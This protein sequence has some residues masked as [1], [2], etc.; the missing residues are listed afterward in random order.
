MDLSKALDHFEKILELFSIGYG[1]VWFNRY[2]EKK[3]IERKKPSLEDID[4]YERI[5][6]ALETIRDTLNPNI[7]AFWEGSNGETT[8]S[9]FHKKKLSLV[10]ESVS[11]D[12]YSGIGELDNIPAINFKRNIDLLRTS[13]Y[14]Y[15]VS[16]EFEKFDELAALHQSYEIGTLVALKIITGR[17]IKKWTG[18][19]VVGFKEKPKLLTDADLAW[20]N[21]QAGRIGNKLTI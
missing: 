8:L 1:S 21:I 18:I 19:L 2:L 10:A 4:H 9:G 12:K 14:G 17:D 7:V 11:D 13:D 6:E 15:I 20:L 5:Q 3:S 16:Y